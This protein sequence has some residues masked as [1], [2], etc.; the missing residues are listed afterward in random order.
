[1][2]NALALARS[3]AADKARITEARIVEEIGKL[4]FADVPLAEVTIQDKTANLA[5]LGKYFALWKGNRD[6]EPKTGTPGSTRKSMSESCPTP[7]SPSSSIS[8]AVS[9]KAPALAAV[10]AE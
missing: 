2:A 10:V 4:A 3:A 9:K 5:L 6:P 7:S 8:T 1:M